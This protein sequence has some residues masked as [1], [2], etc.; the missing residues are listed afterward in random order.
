MSAALS[1]AVAASSAEIRWLQSLMVAALFAVIGLCAAAVFYVIRRVSRPLG[2][3]AAAMAH[4][5]EGDAPP[6]ALRPNDALELRQLMEA[7]TSFKASLTER[8]REQARAQ[9]LDALMGMTSQ[10]NHEIG[11]MIGVISGTAAL[12]ERDGLDAKQTRRIARISKAAERG[13]TLLSGMLA[14]A[15]HQVLKP[16]R[17]DAARIVHGM[18][19]ILELAAG[20]A[21]RIRIDANQPAMIS[22]D[23]A[24]LEQ[25]ILNLVLNA[26]DAMPDGGTVTLNVIA[27]DGD[28]HV[29]VTDSGTGMTPEVRDRAFEPYFTTRSGKGGTGL[30]LPVVYGFVRQSEGTVAIKSQPG[31][32]TTVTL[33]FP[34]A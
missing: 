13:R 20:S 26:R 29:S 28:I 32:G 6:V 16:E 4:V 33:R 31:S 1:T 18:A 7:F 3:I 23:A 8:N 5:P 22:V 19:D 30:G 27:G 9:R 24:M 2:T 15:S 34:L 10:L 14:F 17:I 21:I 11:N 12:I 25:A